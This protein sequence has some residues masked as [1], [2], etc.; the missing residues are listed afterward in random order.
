MKSR[1]WWGRALAFAVLAVS[2]GASTAAAQDGRNVLVVTNSGSP[3]SKQLT[4]RYAEVRRV[5]AGQVISISTTTDEEIDKRRYDT[6]IEIPLPLTLTVKRPSS[7]RT[8]RL[9]PLQ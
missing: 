9:R 8:P 6:E 4:A 3:E 7:T 5:P 2:L 1:P